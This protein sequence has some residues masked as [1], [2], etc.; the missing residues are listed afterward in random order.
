MKISRKKKIWFG[1]CAALLL[2]GLVCGVSVRL[3]INR[4]LTQKEAERWQGESEQSYVQLSCFLPDQAKVGLNEVYAFRYAM[5][6]AFRAAGI[7]WNDTAYPF[8]DAWSHE[9]QVTISGEKR[10]TE[11]PVL[12]VGGQFFA[13]HPLRLISGSYL[14]EDDLSPDRVVL[15]SELAWELFGGVE[16]GG[17]SVQ[18]NGVNFVVGGVVEREDDSASRRAYTG[19]KGFFMSYDAYRAITEQDKVD[20]YEVVVP[21]AVKGFGAQLVSDKFPLSGGESIVNTG[22]FGFERLLQIAKVLPTRA[23]HAGSVRY[24]YWENAARITENECAALTALETALVLPAAITLLVELIRL[25][26]RGKTALEDDLIPRAKEGVE[27]AVRVQAR[28]RWEKKH[29]EER[30]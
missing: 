8:I 21:E 1:I 26:A 2:L 16:L 28:K 27:E 24:P 25:L 4:L 14:S 6:D 18:I 17:M 7:E 10:S 13:F 5:L 20:C 30:N 9:G 23:A 11:A 29:P 12:A 22:R 3:L 19:E 15:D